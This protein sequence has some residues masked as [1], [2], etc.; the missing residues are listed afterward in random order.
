SKQITMEICKLDTG[1]E[2]ITG[3]S[4]FETQIRILN[5][6]PNDHIAF[7]KTREMLQIFLDNDT[8]RP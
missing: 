4:I 6:I 2:D 7:T 1:E 3:D 8:I 5:K